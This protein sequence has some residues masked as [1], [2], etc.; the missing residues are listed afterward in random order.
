MCLKQIREDG[1][2]VRFR[3]SQACC[4]SPLFPTCC[5]GE[6]GDISA[7]A[8]LTPFLIPRAVS[9]RGS[10][11]DLRKK[12]GRLEQERLRGAGE[13]GTDSVDIPGVERETDAALL[14]HRRSTR[15]GRH[16]LDYL[17]RGEDTRFPEPVGPENDYRATDVRA[18]SDT[19]GHTPAA[20]PSACTHMADGREG[21]GVHD[22]VG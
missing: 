14:G 19:D 21:R 22:H 8:I 12:V 13:S 10:Y 20:A 17:R 4:H 16:R 15:R 1:M 7:A 6:F 2:N 3:A 5:P 18:D 9:P 11:A